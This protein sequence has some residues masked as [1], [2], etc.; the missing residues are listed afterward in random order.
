MVPTIEELTLYMLAM[1]TGLYMTIVTAS[2][3]KFRMVG[4]HNAIFA[5]FMLVVLSTHQLGILKVDITFNLVCVGVALYTIYGL[6]ERLR[7]VL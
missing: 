2:I 1:T 4:C 7:H 5:M 3:V 6:R